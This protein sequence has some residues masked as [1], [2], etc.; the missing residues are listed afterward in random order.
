VVVGIK[1]HTHNI[2]SAGGGATI[3]AW[4]I[5]A[6]WSENASRENMAEPGK[7]KT[8]IRIDRVAA[9]APAALGPYFPLDFLLK[10][11]SFTY[12]VNNNT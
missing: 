6:D 4:K 1:V 3:R 5:I 8:S 7:P 10:N 11:T 12:T 2:Y 9:V